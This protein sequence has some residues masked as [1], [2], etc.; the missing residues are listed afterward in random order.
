MPRRLLVALALLLATGRMAAADRITF[1]IHT[2]QENTSWQELVAT[3]QQAEKL[4]Y[5][6]A[7]GYDHF[8]PLRGSKDGP[9]LEGWTM[10]AGLATQTQKIR[11]GLLVTGNT[12]RNPALL[13]KMATTV[14]HISNGRL[15]LGIGAGWEEYEHKA[16]GFQFGTA[17]ERAQRLGEA[18]EVITLLWK[19]GHPSYTGRYYTL[20]EAP[21]APEPIQKPH[22]P[23]V[24]GG[25][26]PKWIMPLVA[27][28]ADEWNVPIGLTPDDVRRRIAEMKAE[29]TRIKRDPCV[30][31][32]SVFLP[33][34][35]IT[36]I[37]LAGPA[38]R[39]GAR[40]LVDERVAGSLLAGSAADIQG[41]L[42]EFVDAGATGFIINVRAPF[43][44]ALL[45][46]FATEVVPAF[47]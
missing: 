30:R 28:Y 17:K 31:K 19:G 47:R 8:A 20:F 6:E 29:C 40:A 32:V 42:R 14:D 1:G 44:H 27:K 22:P 24:I 15:N 26:G 41:R 46:R 35:T 18:L 2:P 5:D 43:D 33:L 23:I 25:Q 4:G 7:W 36:D 39:L 37:P 13:A 11:I 16:Y 9:V 10:L 3:W 21:M 38:T 45:A 12:Y 34:V